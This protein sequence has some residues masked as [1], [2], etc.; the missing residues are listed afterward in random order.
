LSN[1]A[2]ISRPGSPR[3]SSDGAA[4]KADQVLLGDFGDLAFL[5]AENVA[6]GHSG[7]SD[8]PASI[9]VAKGA[10]K[11]TEQAGGQVWVTKDV[12]RHLAGEWR[13]VLGV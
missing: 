9:R 13:L 7:I 1:F 3:P 8:L 10:Y 12:L 6:L 11:Q 5:E 4:W 2:E